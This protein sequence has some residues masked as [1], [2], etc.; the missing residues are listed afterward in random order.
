MLPV[1]F[2]FIQFKKARKAGGDGALIFVWPQPTKD[3]R[4]ELQQLISKLAIEKLHSVLSL[5]SLFYWIFHKTNA[6]FNDELPLSTF[7]C[8]EVYFLSKE[9]LRIHEVN[10]QNVGN[11]VVSRMD[12]RGAIIT[13][14]APV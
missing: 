1:E 8:L 13:A 3:P 10:F 9:N 2:Q 4:A 5:N 14:T 12:L 6:S 7:I 11:S